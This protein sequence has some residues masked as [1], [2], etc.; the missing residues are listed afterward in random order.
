[1]PYELQLKHIQIVVLEDTTYLHHKTFII[2][3]LCL[4]SI[5]VDQIFNLI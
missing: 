3:S 2:Y 5:V 1:M 4:G